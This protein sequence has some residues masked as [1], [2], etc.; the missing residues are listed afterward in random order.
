LISSIVAVRVRVCVC[1]VLNVTLWQSEPKY[2]SGRKR[3]IIIGS[4][5]LEVEIVIPN[6]ETATELAT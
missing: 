3:K 4:S 5:T 1:V 2:E 6:Q